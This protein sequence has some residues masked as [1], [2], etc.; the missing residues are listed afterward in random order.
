VLVFKKKIGFKTA[1]CAVVTFI[2]I[3]I[4]TMGGVNESF[5]INLGDVLCTLCSLFFAIHLMLIG[6]IVKRVD[7]VSLTVFQIGFVGFYNLIASFL[8]ES[9][10]LPSTMES[11]FSIL[12]LGV[13]CGVVAMILQ[14]TA[15]KYT[16]DI[17]AGIIFTLEPVF[18][19]ILAYAFLGET[20]TFAGYIGAAIIVA[21]IVLL[22]LGTHIPKDPVT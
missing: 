14:N 22:E 10:R 15:L 8:L 4:L 20:L 7:A 17:H 3:Y 12:W 18:A 5:G 2:G 9:P 6:Y 11:W 1:L 19:L 13:I 16:T 21:C